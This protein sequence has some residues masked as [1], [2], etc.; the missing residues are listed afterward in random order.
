MIK[1]L[2][3]IGTLSSVTGCSV[4]NPNQWHDDRAN[5]MCGVIEG[6]V[7]GSLYANGEMGGCK[8][9]C[10]DKLLESGEVDLDYKSNFCQ[11]KIKS[12]KRKQN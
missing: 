3:L 6:S 10:S 7:K 9:V 12:G 11:V 5:N 4:I 2:I 8:I 1:S